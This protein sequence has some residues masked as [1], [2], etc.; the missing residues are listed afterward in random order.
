VVKTTRKLI[1]ALLV[2]VAL[3]MPAVADEADDL[4]LDLFQKGIYPLDTFWDTN[5]LLVIP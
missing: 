4:I 2:L 1:L 3:A 5:D